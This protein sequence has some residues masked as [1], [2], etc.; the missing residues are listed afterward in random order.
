M[1]LK[2]HLD[3]YYETVEKRIASEQLRNDADHAIRSAREEER[4]SWDEFMAL[5]NELLE[6]KIQR[7]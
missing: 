2:S 7:A 1:T 4:I 5:R 6:P 3:K